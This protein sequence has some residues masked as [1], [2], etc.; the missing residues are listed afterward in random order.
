MG[1]QILERLSDLLRSLPSHDMRYLYWETIHKAQKEDPTFD[2]SVTGA[3][4]ILAGDCLMD[5]RK[6]VNC[7]EETFAAA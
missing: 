3:L 5:G 1:K 6:T 4:R 2:K 7:S